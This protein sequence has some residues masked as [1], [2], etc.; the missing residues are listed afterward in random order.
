MKKQCVLKNLRSEKGYELS[1]D[2]N[3]NLLNNIR[4][5][6]MNCRDKMA[7][8]IAPEVIDYINRDV[9]PE[10]LVIHAVYYYQGIK[11]DIS[12]K[13]V[14]NTILPDLNNI[15]LGIECNGYIPDDIIDS[16]SDATPLLLSNGVNQ[17]SVDDGTDV[18]EDSSEYF[19]YDEDPDFF[20]ATE[21]HHSVEPE[22]VVRH[23]SKPSRDNN[24][25]GNNKSSSGRQIINKDKKTELGSNAKPKNAGQTSTDGTLQDD[26]SEKY[27][28]DDKKVDGKK[29][30]NKWL[31]IIG[32]VVGIVVVISVVLFSGNKADNTET[33]QSDISQ[34]TD[35]D[36]KSLISNETTEEINDIFIN[37]YDGNGKYEAFATTVDSDYSD[38]NNLW[39]ISEQGAILVAEVGD[40]PQLLFT[41][42]GE[43][44]VP[45]RAGYGAT[46][47]YG[48]YHGQI[49][50]LDF[51]K[52]DVFQETEKGT[53]YAVEEYFTANGEYHKNIVCEFD[54]TTF[55][56][57]LT[58][59]FYESNPEEDT[60]FC[61]NRETPEV[62]DS[63][64]LDTT[65]QDEINRI[66]EADFKESDLYQEAVSS[67]PGTIQE[68]CYEDFDGDGKREAFVSTGD[69]DTYFTEDGEKSLWYL[70]DSG[71]V[72]CIFNNEAYWYFSDKPFVFSDCKLFY[73]DARHGYYVVL[74]VKNDSPV[75]VSMPGDAYYYWISQDPESGVVTAADKREE[76]AHVL[77]YDS[78][79]MSF[80]DTGKTVLND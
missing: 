5:W 13:T 33:S 56:L 68:W 12:E 46:L 66:G 60:S 2:V 28:T 27:S 72:E 35:I 6:C 44:L 38:Y 47:C 76:R 69:D 1:I 67:I 58:D 4:I 42:T 15:V 57:V 11:H 41:E 79:S 71:N 32:A 39:Y 59:D 40:I 22:S 31:V 25:Y 70:S 52:N 18:F 62:S 29:N 77:E 63:Q 26:F 17:S 23:D 30:S 55:E 7:Y 78:S 73:I 3:Q 16:S 19:F 20:D 45:W 36:F 65:F 10:N 37:D 21:K 80:I 48:L 50:E 34:T 43:I 24:L 14:L 49:K 8:Y 9:W 53:I 75:E 64:D 54:P 74:G 61:W 51:C